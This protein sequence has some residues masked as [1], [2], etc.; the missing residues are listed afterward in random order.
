MTVLDDNDKLLRRRDNALT[1]YVSDMLAF[2]ISNGVNARSDSIEFETQRMRDAL[3]SFHEKLATSDSP[4]TRRSS[5]AID[6]LRGATKLVRRMTARQPKGLCPVSACGGFH[7]DANITRAEAI[8]IINGVLGRKPEAGHLHEDTKVWTD[9]LDESAWYYAD[10]QEAT[11]S[12]TYDMGSE[13]ET[14]TGI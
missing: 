10:V 9:N 14:W 2:A 7:P 6:L 5:E 13:Y 11:N 8:K 3:A 12:H 1:E 4:G